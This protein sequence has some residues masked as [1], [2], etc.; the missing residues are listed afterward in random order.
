MTIKQVTAAEEY[1]QD[2]FATFPVLPGVMML[3]AMVQ[4]GR[5]LLESRGLGAERPLVLGMG[6]VRWNAFRKRYVMIAGEVGGATSMLGE[7]YYS[8]ADAPEGPWR[9]ARKIVTHDRY[10]LYNPVHHEFFD[11]GIFRAMTPEAAV[12]ARKTPQ[13]TNPQAVAAAL[14]ETK[15]WLANETAVAAR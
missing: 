3:E 13:S 6:S 10:S 9:W 14:A 2:H 11:Q 4:A 5:R 8:E 12:A 1:L 15:A 7:I